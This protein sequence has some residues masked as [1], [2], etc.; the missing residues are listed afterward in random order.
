MST[1][2]D[3]VKTSGVLVRPIASEGVVRLVPR[4]PAAAA[5]ALAIIDVVRRAATGDAT[6]AEQ[7][8]VLEHL[9]AVRVA[10]DAPTREGGDGTRPVSTSAATTIPT[11]TARR[12]A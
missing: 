10:A 6:A 7:V 2:R 4:R 9:L 12:A 5:Q 1:P 3:T 8:H 11:A